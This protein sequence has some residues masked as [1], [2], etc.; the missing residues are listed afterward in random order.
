TS[1]PPFHAAGVRLWARPQREEYSERVPLSSIAAAAA[2]AF[3][4]PVH[5]FAGLQ[6]V[7]GS[8]LRH[9]RRRYPSSRCTLHHPAW[10][11]RRERADLIE[12]FEV[13]CVKPELGR[14]E[15]LIELVE[16]ACA[17]KHAHHERPRKH[18]SQRDGSDAGA[19]LGGDLAH[20]SH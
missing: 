5:N 6:L 9:K 12:A 10:I 20:H 17:D 1:P 13:V 14:G 19:M 8:A 7:A 11:F 16:V 15:V 4:L 18:E 2:Y 3:G